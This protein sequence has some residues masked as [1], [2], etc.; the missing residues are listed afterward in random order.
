MGTRTRID[1]VPALVLAGL[2]A[3]NR[4]TSPDM[5]N[6]VNGRTVAALQE[7]RNMWSLMGLMPLAEAYVRLGRQ[8]SAKDILLQIEDKLHK[9]RPPDNAN[10]SDKFRFAEQDAHYW[11]LRGLYAEKDNHKLD[12]LVD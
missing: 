2:D 7:E 8:S 11:Y 4:E 10:S 9:M 6:D 3:A 5:A 12:A 1:D